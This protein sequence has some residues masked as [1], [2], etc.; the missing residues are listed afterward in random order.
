MVLSTLFGQFPFPKRL[1]ADS[2]YHYLG[3][4]ELALSHLPVGWLA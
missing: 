4:S 1:F 3:T 2:A